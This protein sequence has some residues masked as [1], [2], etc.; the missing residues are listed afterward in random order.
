VDVAV[1][2]DGD[3]DVDGDVDESVHFL[4]NRSSALSDRRAC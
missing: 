2:V 4:G 1:D 3:G